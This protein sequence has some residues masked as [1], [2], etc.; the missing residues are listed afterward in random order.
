VTRLRSGQLGFEFP[1]G[2][3][4]FSFLQNVQA[5]SES[6]P[7]Y[8]SM[9][10]GP[11]PGGK[12]KRSGP[13]FD[14]TTPS[15]AEA[16]NE[17]SCTSAHNCLYGVKSENL[18]LLVLVLVFRFCTCVSFCLSNLVVAILITYPAFFIT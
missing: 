18:L 13:E 16:K 14:H 2:Q 10:P 17:W 8:Y 4:T 1:S 6:H 12:A 9:V 11:F 15:G 7:T 3:E 5:Y